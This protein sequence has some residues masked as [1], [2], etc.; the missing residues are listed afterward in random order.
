MI[1]SRHGT[2][3]CGPMIEQ[4]RQILECMFG[5]NS[6]CMTYPRMAYSAAGVLTGSSH[7]GEEWLPCCS[8]SWRRSFHQPSSIQCSICFCICLM[9][10]EWEGLCSSVGA[11]QLKDARRFFERNVRINAKLRLRLLRHIFWRRCQ[12]SQLNTMVRS[13]PA[14][15]IHLL[16][17]MLAIMNRVSAFS[18]GNFEVQVMRG[19]RPRTMKSG[20]V[21]CFIC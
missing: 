2:K 16:V 1:W 11:I 13:L 17:T 15:I 9:R 7:V 18:E 21:S 3:G 14:C 19:T 5:T 4:Q 6:P 12:T 20:A 8:V 10:Q